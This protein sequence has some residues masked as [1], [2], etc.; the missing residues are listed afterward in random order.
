MRNKNKKQIYVKALNERAATSILREISKKEFTIKNIIEL[1]KLNDDAPN[2]YIV[3][4]SDEKDANDILRKKTLFFKS[5]KSDIS[6]NAAR[7]RNERYSHRMLKRGR[8][9]IGQ[10]SGNTNLICSTGEKAKADELLLSDP[11]TTNA[12]ELSSPAFVGFDA[13]LAPMTCTKETSIKKRRLVR[14]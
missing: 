1:P 9:D 14:K 12:G 11:N 3:E 4:L 7:T 13:H 6:V 5:H 2:S 8:T 10:E